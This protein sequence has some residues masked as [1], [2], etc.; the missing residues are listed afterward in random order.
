MMVQLVLLANLF[1]T[2][3]MAGVIWIIQVVHYPLFD[4]VSPEQFCRFHQRHSRSI[5]AV[6]ALPWLVE[7]L[8]SAVLVFLLNESVSPVWQ[9][10]VW[11][12]AVMAIFPVALTIW[13]QIPCHQALAN[14][15]DTQVHRRL[16]VTNWLRTLA[17]SLHALVATA[18]MS[19]N[20]WVG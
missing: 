10:L 1:A 5:S 8:T 6:V 18:M 13:L 2:C 3:F 15:F 14:R 19:L 7:L 20:F 12:G 16:V 17:W 11:T 4:H 9:I